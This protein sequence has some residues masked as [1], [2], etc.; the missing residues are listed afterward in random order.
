[1]IWTTAFPTGNWP[2]GVTA[3]RVLLYYKLTKYGV[4]VTE[5]TLTGEGLIEVERAQNAWRVVA[6]SSYF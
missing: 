1:M 4:G 6:Y 3:V 5:H 2:T